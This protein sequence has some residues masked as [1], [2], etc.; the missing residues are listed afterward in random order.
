MYIVT[1][2]KISYSFLILLI[3]NICIAQ[4]EFHFDTSS[5][6]QKTKITKSKDTITSI[7]YIY[8]NYSGI[9]TEHLKLIEINKIDIILQTEKPCPPIMIKQQ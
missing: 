6:Y 5:M 4:K 8:T 1:M 2:K 3:C 9:K 7:E